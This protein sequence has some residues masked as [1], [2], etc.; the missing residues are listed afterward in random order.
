MDSTDPTLIRRK[1]GSCLII[2]KSASG[3][4]TLIKEILQ[5]IIKTQKNNTIYTVN[6][7]STEYAKVSDNIINI[8]F[9]QLNSVPKHSVII[10][11]DVI[12]L[13]PFQ[14]KTVRETINFNAHHKKQRVFIVT[15][16][17]FK[18][19][20]YQL[21]PYFNYV[22]FTSANNN[23]PIVKL[24]LQYFQIEKTKL[25]KW[26]SFFV[27]HAKPFSYF[28]FDGEKQSF[29]KVESLKDLFKRRFKNADGLLNQS[30]P[31]KD[32]LIVHF[33]SFVNNDINKQQ[34]TIIFTMLVNALPTLKHIN[35][36]DLTLKCFTKT[37][38]VL[39][40]SLVD[41]VM[42]LLNNKTPITKYNLF[43]HQYFKKLCKIPDMFIVN[44]KYEMLINKK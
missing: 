19:N 12:T 1:Y 11:E 5:K 34:A 13:T 18:T 27:K 7:K 37:T 42:S 32:D 10:I 31:T 9:E 20:I 17:V 36:I 8:D 2:G 14:A 44:K 35:P 41:Y 3:K 23:L 26:T 30:Q 38:K 39:N 43:L 4:T 24:V 33:D 28:F 29:F 15:H 40:I 6:V 16:H 22:F 25:E 21:I